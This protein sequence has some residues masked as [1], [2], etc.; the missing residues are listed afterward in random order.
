M[1][2]WNVKKNNLNAQNLQ[3]KPPEII[4]IESKIKSTT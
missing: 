1:N 2:K 4:Q 3:K